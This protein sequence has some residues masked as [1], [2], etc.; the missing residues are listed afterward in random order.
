MLRAW[1]L[2]FLR[3]P[4]EST[5]PFTYFLVN[6]SLHWLNNVSCLFLSFPLI[7][8]GLYCNCALIKEDWLAACV[9]LGVVRAELVVFLWR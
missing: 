2:I 4:S 5:E 9:A 1:F 6:T 3:C 8:S 7:T